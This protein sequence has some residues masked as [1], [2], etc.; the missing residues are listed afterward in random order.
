M[1]ISIAH[2]P[3]YPKITSDYM[4]DW[5]PEPAIRIGLTAADAIYLT[6]AQAKTLHYELEGA[7]RD[8][9]ENEMANELEKPIPYELA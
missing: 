6:V 7:L 1:F 9:W 3:K 2:A 5:H 4:P 8:A